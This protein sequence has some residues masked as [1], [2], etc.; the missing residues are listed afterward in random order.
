[1]ATARRTT[2]TK[3]PD[4][5]EDARVTF[6]GDGN[7]VPFDEDTA[8]EGRLAP[9]R[10]F[11]TAGH[12]DGGDVAQVGERVELRFAIDDRQLVGY[13]PTDTQIALV[14]RAT[15][16]GA[17]VGDKVDVFL[18]FLEGTLDAESYNYVETRLEDPRDIRFGFTALG[19]VAYWLVEE[20]NAAQPAPASRTGPRARTGGRKRR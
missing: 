20:F 5:Q 9:V 4:P 8:P 12:T 10:E 14:S 13:M 7:K 2:T 11:S 6:D 15:A 16:R 3:D 1:M 19:E 17:K 18:R